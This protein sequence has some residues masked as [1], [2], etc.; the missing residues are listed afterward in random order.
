MKSTPEAATNEATLTEEQLKAQ[1]IGL[2]IAKRVL[3]KARRDDYT[4]LVRGGAL[5]IKATSHDPE[6]YAVASDKLAEEGVTIAVKNDSELFGVEL[7]PKFTDTVT[8][9]H[10]G[11]RRVANLRLYHPAAEQIYP[12]VEEVAVTTIPSSVTI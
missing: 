10:M 7:Y 6:V 3:A 2:R 4:N 12:P 11:S 5:G 8:V 1:K 9:T